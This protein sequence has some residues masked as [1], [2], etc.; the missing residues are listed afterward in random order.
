MKYF[1]LNPQ[2]FACSRPFPKWLALVDASLH[3]GKRTWYEY[4]D[5]ESR[6]FHPPVP[7][8]LTMGFAAWAITDGFFWVCFVD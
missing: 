7:A 1:V 8:Y 4:C 3:G 6:E 2:N 5:G